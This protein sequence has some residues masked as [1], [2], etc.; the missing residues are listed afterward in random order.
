ILIA[1]IVFTPLSRH[2]RRSSAHC[3]R[4]RFGPVISNS[5]QSADGAKTAS[6]TIGDLMT[7]ARRTGS[8]AEAQNPYCVFVLKVVEG[9]GHSA[10]AFNIIK[11]DS[12]TVERASAE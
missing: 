8:P 11:R 2:L 3:T 7:H 10:V 12:D 6:N 5:G 1:D 9:T 4:H